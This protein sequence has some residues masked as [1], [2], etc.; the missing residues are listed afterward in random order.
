MHDLRIEAIYYFI[1]GKGRE[2]EVHAAFSK[3]G[4]QQWYAPQP[5]LAN[6]VPLTEAI[7]EAVATF[8]SNTIDV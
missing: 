5:I 8:I 2:R 7:N 4:S 1:D 3:H 6:T